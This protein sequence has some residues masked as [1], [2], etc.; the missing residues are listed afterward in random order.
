MTSSSA[1]VVP[2]PLALIV[3]D[4]YGINPAQQTP[5]PSRW[6]RSP[7]S[8]ASPASGHI[9]RSRP[10]ARRS[11]CRRGRWATPRSATSTSARASASCKNSRA[12]APPST[13]GSFFENPA[14]LKAIAHVKRNNTQTPLLRADRPRR[15]P[16]APEPSRR[17]PPARRQAMRSSAS[18]S[19]PSPMA[20]TPRRS[21]REEYM[22]ELWRQAQP[23]SAATTRPESPPSPGATTRWI[24]TTAG[25]ASRASIG[26]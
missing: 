20:A 3:M 5:T 6:R 23:R 7:I 19:T 8:T 13:I 18:T 26:R 14:L 21:A 4:G 16:R 10:L 24:A 22:T 17:L 2:R 9:P 25:I 12:S 11:G 15:R 1:H